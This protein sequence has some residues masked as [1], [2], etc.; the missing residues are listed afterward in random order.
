VRNK[1]SL[2]LSPFHAIY[3]KL[4]PPQLVL[5]WHIFRVYI[6][7]WP[8]M[9][10]K[11]KRG[12]CTLCCSSST[13][14]LNF[15]SAANTTWCMHCQIVNSQLCG[16]LKYEFRLLRWM[17]GWVVWMGDRPLIKKLAATSTHTKQRN[18]SKRAFIN[19]K[20]I[21]G[22]TLHARCHWNLHSK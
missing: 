9:R 20:L 19:F 1:F 14:S 8:L 16:A 11:L 21:D 13:L 17:D 3:K 15:Y 7:I 6:F 10:I 5:F 18:S 12:G 22:C 2:R 4:Q